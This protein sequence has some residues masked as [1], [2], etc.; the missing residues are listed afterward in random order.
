[1]RAGVRANRFA[2]VLRTRAPKAA[3]AGHRV[4]PVADTWAR[5]AP[6]LPA[7]GV[8]RMADLTGLDRL[9]IPV[10]DAI[11]PRSRDT[12]STYSG[13]GL[14]PLA[15]RVSAAMEAVER[16]CAACPRTADEVG[17]VRRMRSRGLNVLDPRDISLQPHPGYAED[18]AIAWIWGFDLIADREILVALA[19]A[20][21]CWPVVGGPVNVLASTN[22]LASGNTEAE[23]VVHGLNEVIERDIWTI[24]ELLSSQ[25][26]PRLEQGFDD[27][28]GLSGEVLA[29]LDPSDCSAEVRELVGRF[30]AAGIELDLCAID[31]D[32]GVPTVLATTTTSDRAGLS[33]SHEGLGTDADPEVAVIR[34]VTEVAQSRAGD[35]SGARED[36]TLVREDVP[37][38]LGHSHRAVTAPRRVHADLPRRVTD[39]AG[40]ASPDLVTDLA[41]TLQRLC[42]AG[43]DRVV[44]VDLSQESVPAV[45]CRV[46][47]PGAE[48]WAADHSRLGTRAV[49]AWNAALATVGG[50]RVVRNA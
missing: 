26:A 44:V 11:M 41:E 35:I 13:K 24:G 47:V 34:A 33:A 2:D 50:T 6:H 40:F 28:L 31:S 22:G 10:F 27:E 43:L 48:S 7:I 15:A 30:A 29:T 46:L 49:R 21:D 20:A 4:E 36:M 42:R 23:A 18:T 25:L 17:S 12:I 14:T 8:T 37:P 5:I 9:G 3:G 19:Q 16:Y 45:V 39:L 38:S 1:M 32:L